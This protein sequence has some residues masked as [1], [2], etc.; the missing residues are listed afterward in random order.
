MPPPYAPPVVRETTPRPSRRRRKPAFGTLSRAWIA[1][2][3]LII[4]GW[5]AGEIAARRDA[6]PRDVLLAVLE[7]PE[8]AAPPSAPPA[9]APV[10][11][12]VAERLTPPALPAPNADA[13]AD[14][15]E[16]SGPPT[17]E[18][19]RKE[20]PVV[21]ADLAAADRTV[22]IL[23]PRRSGAEPKRIDVEEAAA[24]RPSAARLAIILVGLGLDAETT[25][26]VMRDAPA[27]V[28][29]GFA[30]YAKRAPEWAA[31][32]AAAGHETILE[33]PMESSRVEAAA[34]GP[35]VLT[36]DRA[37]AENEKRLE[38]MLDRSTAFRMATHYQG[39]R[40][41]ADPDAMSTIARILARR[42]V[43]YIDDGGAGEAG[44]AAVARA[45]G[46][47]RETDIVLPAI[48]AARLAGLEARALEEGAL[49]AKAPA[50][51]EA[52]Q[53]MRAWAEGLEARGVRLV[54]PS[55]LVYAEEA[56][57]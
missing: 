51:A 3:A 5:L 13:D 6:A 9:S 2:V 23:T 38:W 36:T 8:R 27:P 45:G 52:A 28:A 24:S 43:A 55:E 21:M 25:E 54:P 15:D 4:G 48:D 47:W 31:R 46:A 34:L 41:R 29:F 11:E 57:A 19:P 44:A 50:S 1:L 37:P 40:F 42:G 30:P 10:V 32:A 26:R 56:P 33:I 12:P 17:P 22:R 18:T 16:D 53:L 39:D 35:A 20:R 7:L 14:A 49:L